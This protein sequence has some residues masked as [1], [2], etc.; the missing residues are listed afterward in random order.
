MDMVLQ[1]VSCQ[2][3]CFKSTDFVKII[4][5]FFVLF[6]LVIEMLLVLQY[7]VMLKH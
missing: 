3:N 6:C 7:G 1:A 5:A 4:N 2:M